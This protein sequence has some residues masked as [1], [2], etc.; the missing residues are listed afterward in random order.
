MGLEGFVDWMDPTV[1]QS[2]EEREVEMSS[3]V[4][5]FVARMHKCVT[6][7]QGETTLSFEGSDDKRF[8]K[9]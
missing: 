3:L 1:S 8:K 5:G 2:A 9:C 6:S 7:A 4:V